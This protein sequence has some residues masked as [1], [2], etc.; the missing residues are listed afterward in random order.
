MKSTFI[1]V[2]NKSSNV[3]ASHN[4]LSMNRDLILFLF[5][6]CKPCRTWLSFVNCGGRR[7]LTNSSPSLSSPH[8]MYFNIK[9]K[10]ILN[11]C[12]TFYFV[13]L[14]CGVIRM[15]WYYYAL[16][17]IFTYYF[18]LIDTDIYLFNFAIT[19]LFQS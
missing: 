13:E 16:Y 2:F 10:D 8:I 12:K 6:R 18:N 1:A 4:P 19:S 7:E 11:I 3:Y 15:L 17:Q 9:F 5:C 14:F